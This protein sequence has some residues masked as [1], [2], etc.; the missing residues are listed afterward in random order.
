MLCLLQ[1]VGL[2]SG[3]VYEMLYSL[4]AAF[5]YSKLLSAYS[6]IFLCGVSDISI[7]SSFLSKPN[8]I[9]VLEDDNSFLLRNCFY[10]TMYT[11]L[12]FF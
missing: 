3:V 2:H 7:V 10:I 11:A 8:A 12:I 4:A 5:L 6:A 1:I 9:W